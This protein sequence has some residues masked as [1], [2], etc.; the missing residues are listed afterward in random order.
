M[1]AK[2]IPARDLYIKQGSSYLS[3]G[4][5]KAG[6]LTFENGDV[7]EI[8]KKEEMFL[9]ELT[10]TDLDLMRGMQIDLFDNNDGDSLED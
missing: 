9:N 8:G 2:I 3:L 1:A 4:I 5:V 10:D 6:R 7:L